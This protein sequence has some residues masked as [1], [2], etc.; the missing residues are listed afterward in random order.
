MKHKAKHHFAQLSDKLSCDKFAQFLILNTA[1]SKNS[2]LVT[3]FCH[4]TVNFKN[5]CQNCS[6]HTPHQKI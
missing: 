4:D 2:E 3:D 5:V 1:F 6:K